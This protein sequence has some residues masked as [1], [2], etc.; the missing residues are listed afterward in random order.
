[1]SEW[2]GRRAPQPEELSTQ[3]TLPDPEN[4]LPII[5]PLA[6]EQRVFVF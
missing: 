4:S 5:D 3:Y 6:T 1:M 2:V